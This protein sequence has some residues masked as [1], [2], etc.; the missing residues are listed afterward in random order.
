M[1]T[2]EIIAKRAP[3]VFAQSP[4]DGLSNRYGFIPTISVID[5]L[6]V[7]GWHPINVREQHVRNEDKRG[8]ARHVVRFR[9]EDLAPIV[10]DV[11]PE[12]V[13]ENSHDGTSAYKMHAGMFRLVCSNGMVT[14]DGE[15]AALS[16]RHSGDVVGRVIEGAADLVE[17]MPRLTDGIENMRTV[18]LDAEEQRIFARAALTLRY[19]SDDHIPV[20][21]DA[22]LRVRRSA[23]QDNTLWTVFNRVQENII[24]GGLRGFAKNGQR[25]TTREVKSIKEDIRLN[26]ALWTLAEQMKTLKG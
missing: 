17:E 19:D 18:R 23:D 21:E 1:L 10:G 7:E 12:I 9:R 4:Y 15:F 5:A 25:T 8:F 6:R 16:I 26:K 24:R 13:L 3:S 14:S 20:S 2:N 22:L 11:F